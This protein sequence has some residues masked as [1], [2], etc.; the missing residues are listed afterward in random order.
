MAQ[1][2]LLVQGIGGQ[3][4]LDVAIVE[5]RNHLDDLHHRRVSRR[6]QVRVPTIAKHQGGIAISLAGGGERVAVPG[7][8]GI[9]HLGEC[10]RP[11]GFGEGVIYDVSA[12]PARAFLPSFHLGHQ[13]VDCGIPFGFDRG[14]FV[15]RKGLQDG[16]VGDRKHVQIEV[17]V[18]G[19]FVVELALQDQAALGA[20]QGIEKET[21]LE[22]GRQPLEIGLPLVNRGLDRLRE[23]P[24]QCRDLVAGRVVQGHAGFGE[25][26][27][28]HRLLIDDLR[29]L[30][31][32]DIRQA[33]F[34]QA[35]GLRETQL[36]HC[37][38]PGG[39]VG[40]GLGDA[41]HGIEGLDGA[42][43]GLAR[44]RDEE[45]GP[46]RVIPVHAEGRR[47]GAMRPPINPLV[48]LAVLKSEI[49]VGGRGGIR[50]GAESG[51]I[52]HAGLLGVG[53]AAIRFLGQGQQGQGQRPLQHGASRPRKFELV[54]AVLAD[55]AEGPHRRAA[56][57]CGVGNEDKGLG[58]VGVR[59]GEHAQII[60]QGP[61]GVILLEGVLFVGVVAH[62]ARTVLLVDITGGLLRREAH[63]AEARSQHQAVTAG[64]NRRGLQ[65]LT[66]QLAAGEEHLAGGKERGRVPGTGSGQ[67]RP[68][69]PE[70]GGRI[71]H[72]RTAA[73][74]ASGSAGN[75]A[76]REQD[77][78]AW[79]QGGRVVVARHRRSRHQGGGF[80]GGIIDFRRAQ[81]RAAE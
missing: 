52:R 22:M 76:T 60:P 75:Q 8:I 41:G 49:R 4:D 34:R 54:A 67:R 40:Y 36:G 62:R 9:R 26:V 14:H 2:H 13:A 3:A 74:T 42:Y 58:G 24:G 80:R 32:A 78:A 69:G 61:E 21:G 65:R 20:G 1:A 25:A 39:G 68:N 51:G 66:A 55:D 56:I 46:H 29:A 27:F 23:G 12:F 48:A 37:G 45:F 10:G 30:L 81:T 19:D 43:R 15:D 63:G 44:P 7:R 73:G 31:V 18:A 64:R 38:R 47:A 33:E 59:E 16:D 70:T 6:R 53:D 50:C 5:F 11:V 35:E 28:G 17:I 72:F 79:Q 71:I 77:L 57:G